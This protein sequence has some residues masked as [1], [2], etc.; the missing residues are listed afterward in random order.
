MRISR[1]TVFAKR[2]PSHTHAIQALIDN[3]PIAGRQICDF[4]SYLFDDPA[5]LVPEDLRID[6][7]GDRLTIFVRVVVG[8]A[9]E[10]MSVSA[11]QADSRDPH[12]DFVRTRVR[13]W[14]VTHFHALNAA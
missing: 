4:T 13:Q 8:M 12:Y 6:I 1:A 5:D 3:D 10:N 2:L 9:R 14:H 11:T 7:K